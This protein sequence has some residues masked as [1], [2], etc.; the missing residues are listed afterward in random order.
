MLSSVPCPI[1]N[2]L[3]PPESEFI[4][5]SRLQRICT[6]RLLHLRDTLILH[7]LQFSECP[8][9]VPLSLRDCVAG[10]RGGDLLTDQ[11]SFFLHEM[12]LSGSYHVPASS[13]NSSVS[14]SKDN[15]STVAAGA[16][17]NNSTDTASTSSPSPTPQSNLSGVYRL[18]AASSRL[19]VSRP[20]HL[21]FQG[22]GQSS[23]LTDLKADVTAASLYH[24]QRRKLYVAEWNTA[25]GVV[26]KRSRNAY[27]CQPPELRDCPDGF[28]DMVSL[29]NVSV[30]SPS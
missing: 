5:L 30:S 28:F 27:T 2:R 15:T 13:K 17:N 14:D 26:L 7:T 6:L 18:S 20:E 22:D 25:E 9:A 23:V 12:G 21:S 16:L 1:H 8:Y 3:L 24:E 11:S 19:H 4:L 29:L 10:L